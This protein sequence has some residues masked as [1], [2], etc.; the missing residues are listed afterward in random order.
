[1]TLSGYDRISK[2]GRS[3][4]PRRHAG[5]DDIQERRTM[6][7]FLQY[8]SLAR[9]GPG[10]RP[11]VVGALTCGALLLPA[12]GAQ[13]N[14]MT[15]ADGTMCP[16]AAGTPVAGESAPAPGPVRTAS[17]AP[18]APASPST[19]AAQPGRT[20]SK[21]GSQAPSQRAAAQAQAQRPATTQAQRPATAAQSAP[22]AASVASPA[23]VGGT[24]TAPRQVPVAE[25]SVVQQPRARGSKP[26]PARHQGSRPAVKSMPADVSPVGRGAPVERPVAAPVVAPSPADS[27]FPVTAAILFG[28]LALCGGVVAVGVVARRLRAATAKRAASSSTF[29]ESMDAGI[30][31][32]LQ[33]MISATRAHAL[34]V[35]DGLEEVKDDREFSVTR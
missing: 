8:G 10:I 21:P 29:V 30:E 33:A 25:P 7:S 1:M 22:K 14:H 32:E 13:A 12:A 17:T 24:T 18:I 20:A 31:A 11:L 26:G 3:A 35:P 23:E 6:T 34:R 2:A 28:L 5:A 27:G 16:H 4:C 9:P 15:M 19:S